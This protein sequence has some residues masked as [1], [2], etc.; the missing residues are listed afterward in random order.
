MGIELVVGNKPLY[1][2][3]N[4]PTMREGKRLTFNEEDV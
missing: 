1:V 3:V 4:C 2:C